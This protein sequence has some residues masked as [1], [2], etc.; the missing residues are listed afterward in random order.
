M[1]IL[2][3]KSFDSK[4]VR[5]LI[6][7]IYFIAAAILI[8]AVVEGGV[9]FLRLAPPL[10]AEY[11]AYA[12][13]PWLP[14]KPRPMSRITGRNA[15]DEFFYDYRHNS[16]GFRDV[17]H[18]REKPAGVFRILG[19][20]DSFTYGAGAAF[21]E[22]YLYQLEK[23]LNNRPGARPRIEII[24]AG[25]PRFWPEPERLLLQLYGLRYSP[26]LIMVAF[27]ANDV[28]DTFEGIHALRVTKDGALRTGEAEQLGDFGAWLYIHSHAAR[29]VLKILKTRQAPRPDE[30][31][32]PDGYHEKDWRQVEKEYEKMIALARQIKANIVFIHIPQMAPPDD[33]AAYPARRLSVWCE[34]R[35]VLF[36]DVMPAMKE[37]ARTRKIYYPKDG[38]CT[39]EGYAVI[40][41]AINAELINKRIVP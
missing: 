10:L 35:N 40:A 38:H 39:P 9:R 33:R 12:D 18:Q 4:P 37:A 1:I 25:I 2:I 13:D 34:K 28:L 22:T 14:H 21:E 7:G 32:R 5:P 23:K 17:E 16:I 36:I 6:R 19:L 8:I 27:L 30:V 11:T 26:D 29:I 41:E 3:E 31:N 20:G 24:K 15:T